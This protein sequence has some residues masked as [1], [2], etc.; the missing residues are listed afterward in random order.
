MRKWFTWIC[1]TSA[2]LLLAAA[3]A[4]AAPSPTPAPTVAKAPP[5]AATSA[6]AAAPAAATPATKT[7]PAA[8]TPAAK[9]GPST[10][11]YLDQLYEAAKKENPVRYQAVHR[12]ED[13]QKVIEAFQKKYPGVR[14]TYNFKGSP[15][16]TVQLVAEASQGRFTID[17]AGAS[18]TNIGDLL[19]RDIVVPLTDLPGAGVPAAN[20]WFDQRWLV[21]YNIVSPVAYNTKL[22]KAEEAPKT[23]QDLLD[24]RWKGRIAIDSRGFH[25]DSFG[26]EPGWT[27]AQIVK[28][29]E[30]LKAQDP[31]FTPRGRDAASKLS[32]GEVA[33]ATV[34]MSDI[35]SEIDNGS[36]VAVAPVTPIRS[37]PAGVVLVKGSPSPNASK[38]FLAWM[39][40]PEGRSL[41]EDNGYVALAAP[42]D[43]SKL[44]KALCDRNMNKFMSAK[45]LEEKDK[46]N[47]WSAAVRKA[48]GVSR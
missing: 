5:P 20:L 2:I 35:L 7:A 47:Q 8:A 13:S 40:T 26:F 38:L 31:I 44:A 41:M 37:E 4:T 45:T 34:V 27:E 24:P 19:K 48:W 28:F 22:V 12:A 30:G 43:A 6:P 33:V 11:A 18:F 46:S 29:A 17:L 21:Y 36:P 32:I 16:T 1:V 15:E 42:C 10:A 39:T 23:W 25:L 14:V 9:A 3:C